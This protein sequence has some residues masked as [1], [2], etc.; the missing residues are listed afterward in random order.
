MVEPPQ[1]LELQML[2][3]RTA[4]YVCR[5]NLEFGHQKGAEKIGVVKKLHK[6]KFSFLFPENKYNSY[7]LFKV[8]LQSITIYSSLETV[9]LF[10]LVYRWQSLKQLKSFVDSLTGGALHGDAREE[11][12]RGASRAEPS[13]P[14]A[15]SRREPF[16]DARTH[17][18]VTSHPKRIL[19]LM[20]LELSLGLVNWYGRI[21]NEK[22][23]LSSI[24]N[25]RKLVTCET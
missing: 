7:Y 1:D 6:E 16:W 20:R 15:Q 3:D 2:I 25:E 22:M 4:S 10:L 18:Q 13:W 5:Q 12:S 17:P 19:Q 9:C 14:Q 8:R 24:K 23:R 21:S 11:A